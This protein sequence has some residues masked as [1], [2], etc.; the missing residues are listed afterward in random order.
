MLMFACNAEEAE[1]GSCVPGSRRFIQSKSSGRRRRRAKA[2]DLIPLLPV[3][4]AL[5]CSEHGRLS[6]GSF[7]LRF[8]PALLFPS[9]RQQKAC[10]NNLL[11]MKTLQERD[12]EPF[13]ASSCSLQSSESSA[14]PTPPVSCKSPC[15]TTGVSQAGNRT[16]RKKS[17]SIERKERAHLR[18]RL[19]IHRESQHFLLKL[20][21]P[22]FLQGKL[23][24]VLSD[25]RALFRHVTLMILS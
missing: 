9:P 4:L 1:A 8:M 13:A 6:T 2:C 20:V 24:R 16:T 5:T 14:S 23:I 15:V 3:L 21:S 17:L 11:L 25:V 7:D 12:G 19:P 22:R 10:L 18:K